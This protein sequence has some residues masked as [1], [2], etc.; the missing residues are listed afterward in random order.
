MAA[1]PPL[2]QQTVIITGA[3]NGLGRAIATAFHEAGSTVLLLDYD[4]GAL[5]AL[6]TELRRSSIYPVDLSDAAATRKV[7]ARI[8]AEHPTVHTLVHNAG[9]LKPEPF[10]EMTEA[11]WDLTFNVGLQAGYLLTRAYWNA[12]LAAGSGCAIYV[13]SNSGIRADWGEAPYAATKHALEGFSAALAL[14]GTAH[15]VFTHTVTPGKAMRTP[16]SEQNYPPELKATWVDPLA[17]TPAFL[18][19]ATC[20]DP[21]LSGK[22]LSAWELSEAQ[23][24]PAGTTVR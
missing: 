17:L 12:W 15:G 14:E 5:A 2:K 13:S 20:P 9:F 8:A 10:A 7:L 18:Y 16:M 23:T 19:L 22:R 6:H 3:A 24:R 11:R 1:T 4:A 21:A